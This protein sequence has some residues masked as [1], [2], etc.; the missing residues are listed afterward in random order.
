M[1]EYLF[2]YAIM[3]VYRIHVKHK[4][5]KKYIKIEYKKL[6]YIE[7]FYSSFIT[8]GFNFNGIYFECSRSTI[9]MKQ[10]KHVTHALHS[11]MLINI[12][13][14]FQNK[15]CIFYCVDNRLGHTE[16]KH[17]FH[18]F[19]STLRNKYYRMQ[20]FHKFPQPYKKLKISYKIHYIN[21]QPCL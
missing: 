10:A 15:S 12:S 11:V 9:E 14:K 1:I 19:C 18:K 13:F 6:F 16:E 20:I 7:F 2:D 3:H 4:I 17:I 8:S 5:R 21:H